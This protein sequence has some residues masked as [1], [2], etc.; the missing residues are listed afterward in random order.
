MMKLFG[1]LQSWEGQVICE[2]GSLWSSCKAT[3]AFLYHILCEDVGSNI[4]ERYTHK[5]N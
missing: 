3:K 4:K 5:K 1:G 2:F